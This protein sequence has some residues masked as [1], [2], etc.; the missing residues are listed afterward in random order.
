MWSYHCGGAE[1]VVRGGALSAPGY[2]P[3]EDASDTRWPPRLRTGYPLGWPVRSAAA[4]S[5]TNNGQTYARQC[6]S[7]F[8]PLILLRLGPINSTLPFWLRMI[9]CPTL[10]PLESHAN[11]HITLAYHVMLSFYALLDQRFLL[12]MAW[13][14]AHDE[15]CILLT[16][17]DPSKNLLLNE[18]RE[19]PS[20]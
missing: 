11:G 8:N 10:H 4:A 6:T 2:S 1:S 3:L 7:T 18:Y 5:H 19:N 17:G 16:A 20:D 15:F 14:W 13:L 12:F 9:C